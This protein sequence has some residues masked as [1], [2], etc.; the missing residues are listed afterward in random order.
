MEAVT[1]SKDDEYEYG[2]DS[3][4]YVKSCTS[5]YDEYEYGRCYNMHETYVKQPH[6]G[7]SPSSPPTSQ[8]PQH[9][10][11]SNSYSGVVGKPSVGRV[12]PRSRAAA[13]GGWGVAPALS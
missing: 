10:A 13:F 6:Q 5:K 1:T 11:P 2:Q 8:V 3:N 12:R 4:T 7:A 9:S